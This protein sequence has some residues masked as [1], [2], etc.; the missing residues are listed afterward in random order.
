MPRLHD[1]APLK[2]SLAP[3]MKMREPPLGTTEVK[4]WR[5]VALIGIFLFGD[6]GLDEQDFPR[7]Q[8]GRTIL[9]TN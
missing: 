8:G 6:L 2:L 4:T 3:M 9:T 1:T 5:A 7:S